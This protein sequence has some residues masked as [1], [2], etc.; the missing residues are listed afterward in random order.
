M[1]LP[2]IIKTQESNDTSR[3]AK[4]ALRW[5]DEMNR[6]QVAFAEPDIKA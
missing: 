3:S 5:L 2:H 4:I 1:R 6:K